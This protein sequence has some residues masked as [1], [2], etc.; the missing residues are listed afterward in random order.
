M[1]RRVEISHKT[2]IFTVLFLLLL[3][4]LFQIRQVLVIMLVGLILMAA[5][6]RMVVRMERWRIPRPLAILLIYILIFGSF[7]SILVLILPPLLSQT[8]VFLANLTENIDALRPLGIDTS[9]VQEQARKLL[10]NFTSF[11]GRIV[12]VVGGIFGN[13]FVF[14][15][16][17]VIGFYLLLERKNLDKHLLR[18]FGEK[19]SE[20]VAQIVDKIEQR[21]GKW[22][23][24]QLSLMVLVGILTYIGLLILGLD[25][26]LPLAIL[27][28]LLEIIPNIGPIVA[29]I[30]GIIAGLVISP[31]MGLATAIMYI[32]VQQL[33]N[34][35]IVPQ[36]FARE[37]GVSPLVAIPAL[38]A[39]FKIGGV[40]G[41][42]LAI[43]VVILI[44]ILVAE[45]FTSKNG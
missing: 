20:R 14:M 5:F 9:L 41:A 34:Q 45:Y 22:L 6:N 27:A 24:A 43:P 30:P 15:A 2:I 37:T 33:E 44:E 29:S 1:P 4:F 25:Y 12:Q 35:V 26:A 42:F 11:S 23:R 28:G 10:S 13:I 3:W 18:L 7:V 16:I 36:V 38:F 19:S 21:L 17:L 40:A 31:W 32:V 39:G 8:G